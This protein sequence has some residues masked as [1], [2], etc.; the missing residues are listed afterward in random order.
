MIS[1]FCLTV[2][3]SYFSR[4]AFNFLS[5]FF[6]AKPSIL[7]PNWTLTFDGHLGRDVTINYTFAVTQPAKI[8]WSVPSVNG[9]LDR[10]SGAFEI[11]TQMNETVGMSSL[12]IRNVEDSLLGA[13]TFLV[14]N[15]LGIVTGK[16]TVAGEI[17]VRYPL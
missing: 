17:F 3:H 2:T 5:T 14:S 9:P 10:S 12:S 7:N 1:N 6:P 13:V 4:S 11:K 8:L 16:S 15:S